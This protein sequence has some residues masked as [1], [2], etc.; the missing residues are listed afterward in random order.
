MKTEFFKR[1]KDSREEAIVHVV[2]RGADDGRKWAEQADFYSVVD[3]AEYKKVDQL[4]TSESLVD[5]DFDDDGI[6]KYLQMHYYEG[7][8]SAVKSFFDEFK[9][10]DAMES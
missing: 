10:L 8:L 5:E 1:M 4:F 7:F 6:P 3:V 2:Q 9:Q